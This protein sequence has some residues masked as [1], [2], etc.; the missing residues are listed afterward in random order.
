MKRPQSIENTRTHIFSFWLRYVA[1]SS[2]SN[3]F[4]GHRVLLI[5]VQ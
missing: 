4:E 1:L 3:L 2:I 5:E